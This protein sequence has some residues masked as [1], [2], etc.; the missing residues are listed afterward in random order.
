MDRRTFIA[1]AALGT[2]TSVRVGPAQAAKVYLIGILS[3]VATPDLAG[4][5]PRSPY[6]TALLRGF[7]DRGY[8]YGRDFVTEHRGAEGKPERYPVLA[9]ELVSLGPDVIVAAGPGLP[10]LRKATSTIPIVMAA[11]IDPVAEGLVQSLGRPGTNFT[12]LSHQFPETTGKRLELLKELIPGPGL[13]AVLWDQGSKVSWEAANAAARERGW[14]LLSLDIA[15]PSE[16]DGAFRAAAQAGASA[17]LVLTGQ[18][19]FPHRKRIIELASLSRLP[20]VYDLRPYAEAGGLMSHGA[21]LLEIWYQA[22]GFV[23]RILKGAKPAE[24]PIEQPTKFELV[25]NQRAANQIGLTIP[26]S[27]LL[28]ANEVLQ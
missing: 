7:A 16:I 13:V 2:L 6:G 5:K 18:I 9:S 3:V 15:D 12:G 1:G 23:D 28:Q 17:L 26:Q 22:A 19:A 21:N 20:A 4:P 24:M 25:I 27:I 10:A 11:A 8:A 14:R